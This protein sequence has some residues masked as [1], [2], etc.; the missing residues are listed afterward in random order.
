MA[1]LKI[2]QDKWLEEYRKKNQPP[3]KEPVQKPMTLLDEITPKS[4]PIN[5]QDMQQKYEQSQ[6]LNLP[7]FQSY[8]TEQ[9][10]Y[11]G[12]MQL[13]PEQQRSN[14]IEKTFS[15][16]GQLSRLRNISGFAGGLAGLPFGEHALNA[17]KE[18]S[19]E[20]KELIDY[21]IQ[22]HP[23]VNTIGTMAG[24]L[25]TFMQT[26]AALP[27]VTSFGK[28]GNFITNSAAAG[29]VGMGALSATNDIS[30]D[31]PYYG[32]PEVLKQT[33]IGAVTGPILEGSLGLVGKGIGK[34]SR[35]ITKPLTRN[36][37]SSIDDIF[38][39]YRPN[40]E[41]QGSVTKL[42]KQ[43][44]TQLE[45]S[46]F[47]YNKPT[48]PLVSKNITQGTYKVKNKALTQAE[49]N[50][51]D[52][53]ETLRNKYQTS[54]IKGAISDIVNNNAPP[55]QRK[56]NVDTKYVHDYVKA[57]DNIDL[58]K[59]I[60][61][62]DNAQAIKRTIPTTEQAKLKRVA[63]VAPEQSYARTQKIGEYATKPKTISEKLNI[64]RPAPIE[65]TSPITENIKVES[66]AIKSERQ[67]PEIHKMTQSEFDVHYGL[68]KAPSRENI[69][70]LIEDTGAK[71]IN[72]TGTKDIPSLVNYYKKKYNIP[73]NIQVG[74]GLKKST[75]LGTTEPIFDANGNAKG[76]RIKLNPNQS[77]EGRIGSLRHEIEHVI[78]LKSGFKPTQTIFKKGE[79]QGKTAREIYSKLQQGEHSK[80]KWFEADYIRRAS[81]KDALK[82]GK[83]VPES[84]LKEYPD[85][86]NIKQAKQPT[87]K[88]TTSEI[89]MQT[90]PTEP[91]LP[92][93]KTEPLKTQSE[94]NSNVNPNKPIDGKF[95]YESTIGGTEGTGKV[96]ERGYSLNERTNLNSEKELRTMF[97]ENPEYYKQL[98]NKKTLKV[99]ENRF[100]QGYET[101]LEEFNST[102]KFTP[103]DVP[104]SHMLANEAVKRGEFA[105]AR[106]IITIIAEKLTESGQF[107]QAANIMRK[108]DP[109][110]FN[111]YLERQILRLN[112]DG[113]R[114]FGKKWKKVELSDK[115][116]KEIYNLEI[117]D[118]VSMERLMNDAYTDIASQLPATKMEKFD[119]WRRMAMLL[120]PK[121]HVRNF[122]GNSIM[123][124]LRKSSD[125]VGA[126]F[127]K[128]FLKEGNRT[129]SIGWSRDKNLVELVNKDWQV[130]KVS[131]MKGGRWDIEG[132]SIG[133]ADKPIFKKGYITKK[134]EQ[135]R[136]KELDKGVLESMNNFSKSSLEAG[137][138]IFLGRAYKDALGQYLK[139]NNLN[140]VTEASK[141]YATRRALEATF[142]ANNALSRLITQAKHV[143]GWGR[144][145]EAAIPFSKTPSNIAKSAFD[146]SPTGIA[147]SL[148]S[149]GYQKDATKAIEEM[150]KGLVGTSVT[151]L[152]F[153]LAMNGWARL[154]RDK[155]K[156]AEG[157]M[158][159]TGELPNS[160]ITPL[161]SYS[162]D[163]AQPVAVPLAAGISIYEAFIKNTKE[164]KQIPMLN[165]V[166]DTLAAGGDTIF[167]LTMLRSI[168]DA[169]GGG[170]NSTTKTIANLPVDYLEQ[171]F[172]T[173]VGQVARSI[174]PVK[175][176]TYDPNYLK[177]FWM[178]LESKIPIL[179]KN[180]PAK[181]NIL[182]EEEKQG[183]VLEQTISPGIFK[184]LDKS[185][186]VNE[187]N[188]LYDK[189]K[190]TEMIPTVAPKYFV[191]EG[192]TIRLS[193]KE[194][195]TMQKF[196]GK[197][198]K[199]ELTDAI[200]SYEYDALET[201][202][203][204]AMYL[205][206][207]ILNNYNLAKQKILED[208]GVD[209]VIKKGVIPYKSIKSYQ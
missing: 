126:I 46:K 75:K 52:A 95:D 65:T 109:A 118:E 20:Y 50:M 66:Q 88:A 137:D 192:K 122:V 61:D 152:G 34:T 131:L 184:A 94:V 176:S 39:G 13:T 101:A 120:N 45:S 134:I 150:S 149:G 113:N 63:G 53:I 38:G 123:M 1:L 206:D 161:G 147:K 4:K 179:S 108:S 33:A 30:S 133:T 164:E 209:T 193:G 24:A 73:E 91:T 207:Y 203:D 128:A 62:I 98:T 124:G 121:T 148:W 87:P 180:L 197:L 2:D 78:D 194:I 117:I 16:A 171:T 190:N 57:N 6:P 155:S 158:N 25:P 127:E 145:A 153:L 202:E 90:T 36:V 8:G 93:N 76:Y 49:T 56:I 15:D 185:P 5:L 170:Y 201:D 28:V 140:N 177:S 125:T 166:I 97:D 105:T 189:T 138:E 59:I 162:F 85:L 32:A 55:L 130:N 18:M 143:K 54:D 14:E 139:A 132:M 146:Y 173:T 188:R 84:V 160:I 205:K 178:G 17:I 83:E 26:G 12:M 115:M 186:L 165:V 3:L 110:A 183:N 80:Y 157:L 100:K 29:G 19:P 92:T 169:L 58:P 22:R 70:N 99:A 204:K 68:D 181:V 69:T 74:F 144:L 119:S 11:Q 41:G 21:S 82:S 96:R 200:D 37:T 60:S 156:K 175:R 167:N 174:D 77:V 51:N 89:K 7:S 102:T 10:P 159:A 116:Q 31:K 79:L 40:I 23:T 47:T 111:M 86:A 44:P 112:R 199:E 141:L 182:G 43:L 107:S 198:N 9:Q 106:N 163:W 172:P 64:K 151:G 208:R 72:K 81:I 129:K 195:E 104:L 136:G 187:L 114:M 27:K 154:N 196:M 67:L 71:V 168:K 35:A 48:Q 135:V 191:F 42:P 142:R 103:D